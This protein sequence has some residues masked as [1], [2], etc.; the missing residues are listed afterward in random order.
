MPA[1][2][3]DSVASAALEALGFALFIPHDSGALRLEGKPPAWL[4]AIWPGLT[5]AEAELATD[6][7]SPFLE[8]FLVDARAAWDA[9]GETRARS[10]P[11]IETGADGTERTLEAMAL[12]SQGRPILLIERMGEIFEAK[13]ATLQKARDTV[14]AYQRLHSEMQ[15]KEI[16]LNC[17]AQEMTGA[18][19][20][21][22]TAFRLIEVEKNPVKVRQLLSLAARATE[23]QEILINRVLKM[24]AAEL[25]GLYGV[26][27]DTRAEAKLG[28]VLHSAEELVAPQFAEKR[29]R[30]KIAGEGARNSSVSM[31]ADHLSRVLASL[32]QTGLENAADAGEVELNIVEEPDSVLFQM[33][34]H[35]PPLPRDIY[36]GLF[37]AVDADA[38]ETQASRLALQFCRMAVENCHGQVG[39]TPDDEGATCFWIRLPKPAPVT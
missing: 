5:A 6:Q 36:E 9:G 19:S 28:N 23:E 7:A 25:E 13:K 29:V 17:I 3:S 11:W 22:I 2:K 21:T 20:N 35:G 37:S 12:T 18:L 1:P 15:K 31:D 27:G 30:L 14:I 24:F 39:Y 32:L 38:T 33:F 8:N 34:D 4:T 16:L 26:S 10:G